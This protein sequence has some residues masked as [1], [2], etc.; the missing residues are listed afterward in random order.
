MLGW[1]K[2]DKSGRA[3]TSLAL[4]T[5]ENDHLVYVG[6]VGTGLDEDR[7]EAR[8]TAADRS[9]SRID[10]DEGLRIATRVLDETRLDQAVELVVLAY[11]DGP[12]YAARG[13]S[14]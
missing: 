7:M 6:K 9:S 11:D 1:Q 10:L 8:A 12:L 5:Y 2:S 13:I 14:G 4:G 3:F